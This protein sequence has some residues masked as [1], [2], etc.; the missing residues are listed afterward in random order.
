MVFI[1]PN[2][3]NTYDPDLFGGGVGIAMSDGAAKI[4]LP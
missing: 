3:T 1:S 4:I 2:F